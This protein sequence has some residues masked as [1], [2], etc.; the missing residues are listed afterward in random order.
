MKKLI[1]STVLAGSMLLSGCTM[2]DD[3]V[4]NFKSNTEGLDRKITVYSQTGE[5]IAEYE[6]KNV[7]TEVNDGGQLII[8]LNG[9]R[10]QVL[11]ANVIIEENTAE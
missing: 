6:G 10:V 9:K 4:T 11:N 1:V 2:W 7:R 3:T 8:N 5:V